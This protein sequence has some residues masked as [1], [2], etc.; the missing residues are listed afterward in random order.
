MMLGRQ[1]GATDDG[2][3]GRPSNLIAATPPEIEQLDLNNISLRKYNVL[4]T[5][6]YFNFRKAQ[7]LMTSMVLEVIAITLVAGSIVFLL[8]HA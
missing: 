2:S 1:P 6:R 8:A 4:L 7:V 3:A 5:A